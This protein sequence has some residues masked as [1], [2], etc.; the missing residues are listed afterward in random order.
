M[1]HLGHFDRGITERL[2][3]KVVFRK[4]REQKT[5]RRSARVPVTTREAVL[6]RGGLQGGDAEGIVVIRT[7]EVVR[8]YGRAGHEDRERGVQV[9]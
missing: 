8:A 5:P 9:P 1:R 4:L 2:S 7:G 3:G 6:G